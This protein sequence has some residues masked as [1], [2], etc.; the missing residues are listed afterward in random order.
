MLEAGKDISHWFDEATGDILYH[1]DPITNLKLPFCPQGRFIHVPPPTPTTNWDM[2]YE[3]PWWLDSEKYCIGHLSAKTRHIRIKN[4]LTSQ[5]H[6]LEVP[7]EETIEEIKQRYLVFNDHASSYIWKALMPAGKILDNDEEKE[8]FDF[9]T[10]DMDKT[11]E[12]NGVVDYERTYEEMLTQGGI[13]IPVIHLYYTDDL[14]E[15]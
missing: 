7:R 6:E 1:V 14:T 8:D 2:S 4:V 9:V 13:Y 5:H 3:S 15:A 10:L 11:L 12:D